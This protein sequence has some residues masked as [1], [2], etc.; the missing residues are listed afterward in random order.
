MSWFGIVL[1]FLLVLVFMLILLPFRLCSDCRVSAEHSCKN[2]FLLQCWYCSNIQGSKRGW[3]QALQKG[4][5]S[6]FVVMNCHVWNISSICGCFV[7]CKFSID[8]Y[9][10][11][12]LIL[13]S[14]ALCQ[15]FSNSENRMLLW[16]GSRLTNWTGILSQGHY[17]Y[18][19]IF[20]ILN[21]HLCVSHDDCKYLSATYAI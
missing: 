19:L 13:L 7:D 3:N 2:T 15:Q 8:F 11:H 5:S 18:Q 9:S 17:F 10:N 6:S 1:L 20:Y 12:N 21:V 4:D 14:I 16:H